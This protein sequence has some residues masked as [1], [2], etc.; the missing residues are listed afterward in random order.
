MSGTSD[1][2]GNDPFRSSF[3]PVE[4]AGPSMARPAAN[5]RQYRIMGQGDSA[6]DFS[7]S[8][9]ME[10]AGILCVF[11]IF[12]TARLGQKIRRSPQLPLCGIAL[13]ITKQSI[14]HGGCEMKPA[15]VHIAVY[16][17]CGCTC[18]EL[19]APSRV[20]NETLICADWGT[21]ETLTMLEIRK[22]RPILVFLIA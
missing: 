15:S 20:D 21:R 8:E 18:Q 19:P 7:P 4:A 13:I 22:V 17:R 12:H 3:L 1:I 10:N 6:R 16:P 14:R 11:P 9:S 2:D 5:L